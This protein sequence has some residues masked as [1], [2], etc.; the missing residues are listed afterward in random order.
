MEQVESS[1]RSL[2]L[3]RN[4]LLTVFKS[5]K[6]TLI[7][8]GRSPFF[9]TGPNLTIDAGTGT[10]SF[11]TVSAFITSVV[12]FLLRVETSPIGT[13]IPLIKRFF[14]L[15]I[16]STASDVTSS[17][18]SDIIELWEFDRVSSWLI[19]VLSKSILSKSSDFNVVIDS[20]TA[21]SWSKLSLQP[22]HNIFRVLILRRVRREWSSAESPVHVVPACNYPFEYEPWRVRRLWMPCSLRI[23]PPSELRLLV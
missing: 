21:V 11:M 2:L 17:N 9:G 16:L 3:W 13:G 18:V 8:R 19:F 14:N 10:C 23:S 12:S 20:L 7:Y 6:V 4:K 15:F 1:S 5:V 22:L